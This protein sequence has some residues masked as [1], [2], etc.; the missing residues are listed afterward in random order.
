MRYSILIFILLTSIIV[1]SHE[2]GHFYKSKD[3]NLNQWYLKSGAIIHGNFSYEKNGIIYFEQLNGK[4]ISLRL[5]YFSNEDQALLKARIRRIHDFNIV[6]SDNVIPNSVNIHFFEFFLGLGLFLL[7]YFLWQGNHF[8]RLYWLRPGNFFVKSL[9]SFLIIV[10]YL[11]ACSKKNDISVIENMPVIPK[12]RITFLDSSFQYYKPGVTTSSD[13]NYYYISDNGIPEHN[14]MTGITNWQQQVPIP[15]AYFGA[16]SW[17]IPLQPVYAETPL[18][19][20]SNLMKGAVALAINGIPIFNALNNRGEDSY[21]IG[22]LDQW[23]GHCGR[24]DDYHYH[25]APMHL[26]S[27][28]PKI[29]IAFALDGFAVYGSKEP[30]G[31]NMNSLDTCHGH[32]YGAEVYHYHGTTSYPYVVGAMRGKVMLDPAT[33]SPENQILPQAFAKAVRPALTPL[34]GAVITDF[35]SNGPNSYSLT[36]KINSKFGY[37]NYLWDAN[38][39]FTFTFIDTNGTSNTATYQR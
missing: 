30:N 13:N 33:S 23:G 31:S 18:S 14:M 10:V 27:A 24:A 11:Y 9:I 5:E 37:V 6:K 3:S 34:K 38:D 39:K 28:D 12:T 25:A 15:Q 17:A 2:G 7:L 8:I 4:L 29:P 26:I 19:T 22:E 32:I 35:K 1:Q 21:A 20:K 36:Y 16:N